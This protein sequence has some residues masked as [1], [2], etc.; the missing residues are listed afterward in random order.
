MANMV[1][2]GHAHPGTFRCSR[3]RLCLIHINAAHRRRAIVLVDGARPQ[4]GGEKGI[5][6]GAIVQVARCAKS[7]AVL[8]TV[9]GRLPL[10][11][12]SHWGAHALGRPEP[13]P[14]TRKPGNL[15]STVS[16]IRGTRHSAGRG[17]VVATDRSCWLPEDPAVRVPFPCRFH[18]VQARGDS[19]ACGASTLS[20]GSL[21]HSD[22]QDGGPMPCPI[23]IRSAGTC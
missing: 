2:S 9:S 11:S 18:D 21:R 15:P 5:R 16:S 1:L 20:P 4:S 7:G 23:A 22:N 6:C 19:A 17:S 10:S 14:V 12:S 8:A 3:E 13:Q